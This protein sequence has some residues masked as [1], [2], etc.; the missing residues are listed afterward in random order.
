MK[1]RY[2]K[3][4]KTKLT[5]VLEEAHTLI[6]EWNSIGGMGDTKVSQ[7]IVNKIGQI[8]LQGR[9]YNV[10]LVVISQRTAIVSKTILTQC[11]TIITFKSY[12]QTSKDFLSSYIPEN[13]MSRLGSLE[14]QYTIVHGKGFTSKVPLIC[15][16][17]DIKK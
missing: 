13:L 2:E 10:G 9:K 1:E 12:D 6:P 11:N 3:E 14:D 15:K 4:N 17:K 5:I 16:I 7:A 8:S